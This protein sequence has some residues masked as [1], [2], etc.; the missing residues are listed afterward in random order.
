MILEK[1]LLFFG[2]AEMGR[3]YTEGKGAPKLNAIL[4]VLAAPPKN[5]RENFIGDRFYKYGTPDGFLPSPR[6]PKSCKDEM[7]LAQ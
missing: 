1:N 5:K 3:C 7:I 6:T 4:P 2:G